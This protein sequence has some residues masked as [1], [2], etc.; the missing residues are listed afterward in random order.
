MSILK[1]AP[2][3][4]SSAILLRFTP[5]ERRVI[6]G[7]MQA[8]TVKE[9]ANDLGISYETAK[10]ALKT[11]YL[12]AEVHSARE[13]MLKI[14]EHHGGAQEWPAQVLGFFHASFAT[15]DA[16]IAE[17]RRLVRHSCPETVTL[18]ATQS[19][20]ASQ[21]VQLN[22]AIAAQAIFS[23]SAAAAL[24]GRQHWAGS[25][26]A[27]MATPVLPPACPCILAPF[28]WGGRDAALIVAR[29][30]HA[31]AFTDAEIA[32]IRLIALLAEAKTRPALVTPAYT[33]VRA[34][35]ASIA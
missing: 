28:R 19:G 6:D 31:L 1:T 20:E 22:G 2:S 4:T 13:L 32:A 18:V 26:E 27:L 8:Q 23:S 24:A 9:I 15:K 3:E 7:V 33:Q 14:L 34:A 16:L 5:R 29:P 25:S 17:L 11:I 30:P 21:P 10:D 12:K 35:R